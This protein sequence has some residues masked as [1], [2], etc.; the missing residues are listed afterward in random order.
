MRACI[1]AAEPADKRQER[2]ARP[3]N[4]DLVEK[5]EAAILRLAALSETAY[6]TVR[7]DE[8][9]DLKID[10]RFLD[11]RVKRRARPMLRAAAPG[12]RARG[13]IS[14][15]SNHGRRLSMAASYLPNWRKHIKAHVV[16]SPEEALAAALWILH[17]ACA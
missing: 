12:P 16:M 2:E 4:A 13:I 11:K 3:V 15:R 8:A 5:I 6:Q 7:K 10:V 1:E 9:K 17:A 14:R